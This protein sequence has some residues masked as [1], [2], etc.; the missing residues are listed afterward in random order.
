ML[1]FF[2]P[3]THTHTPFF[4]L[5]TP[6]LHLFHFLGSMGQNASKQHDPLPFGYI[7]RVDNQDQFE[8]Q[9]LDRENPT[10][11]FIL[12]NPHLYKLEITCQ[13]GCSG[14]SSNIDSSSSATKRD[15]IVVVATKVDQECQVC[16]QSKRLSLVRRDLA[17]DLAYIDETYYPDVIHYGSSH[18]MLHDE[19]AAQHLDDVDNY[20]TDVDDDNNHWAKLTIGDVA[21]TRNRPLANASLAVDL[22]GR[23]LVKLSPSIGYLHNLTKLD[24]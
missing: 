22:S 3:F 23:S 8:E 17:K 1:P 2:H 18:D 13:N 7:N 19:L 9:A 21:P 16:R 14:F 5:F 10:T 6:L 24:L 15:S 20:I 12:A 4:S 11:D